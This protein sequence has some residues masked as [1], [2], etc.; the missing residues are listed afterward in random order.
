MTSAFP[1]LS[2]NNS[3]S[4]IL[5]GQLFWA[6]NNTPRDGLLFS[7]ETYSW[8]ENPK[9]KQLFDNQGHQFIIDNLDN[10]FTIATIEQ[11]IK[12][13]TNTS[14]IGDRPLTGENLTA[15][16]FNPGDN[17]LAI[18][19]IY[20]DQ[21]AVAVDTTL[22]S[23]G[24]LLLPDPD[25]WTS[26]EDAAG[27]VSDES[28]LNAG[29]NQ[30]DVAPSQNVVRNHVS[31][32][33]FPYT[34]ASVIDLETG[35]APSI[36]LSEFVVKDDF[37]IV[38]RNLFP[39]TTITLT[40]PPGARNTYAWDIDGF[41]FTTG[42]V[43]PN[44]QVDVPAGQ[45]AQVFV[46]TTEETI[47]VRPFEFGVTNPDVTQAD[48]QQE[49]TDRQN[50]DGAII[51]DLNTRA[52][53]SDLQQEITDR[54]NADAAI[55]TAIPNNWEDLD[56]VDFTNAPVTGGLFRFNGTNIE[57]TST[58]LVDVDGCSLE[59]KDET[60]KD[61]CNWQYGT[62]GSA[63]L[64]LKRSLGSIATPLAVTTGTK[65][66]GFAFVGDDL[67]TTNPGYVSSE[68]SSTALEPFTA[69]EAGSRMDF[70]VTPLGTKT[71]V[72][73][74]ST[75]NNGEPVLPQYPD[76]RDDG[77]TG[78]VLYTTA[79]GQLQLGSPQAIPPGYSEYFAGHENGNSSFTIYD[80]DYVTIIW[81]GTA[82]QPQYLQKSTAPIAW[83]RPCFTAFKIDGNTGT[84]NG[85]SAWRR[86]SGR[87]T[88]V[89]DSFHF[90]SRTKNQVGSFNVE[91]FGSYFQVNLTT[92]S[93]VSNFPSY[94]L[95]LFTGDN[96][97]VYYRFNKI[98]G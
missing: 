74:L 33:L 67:I 25:E 29:T 77:P 97:N 57:P 76:T 89:L 20:G 38:V 53:D 82:K 9:L 35:D 58:V 81:N 95:Y 15:P 59:T 62:T 44:S 3:V 75:A 21:A 8:L 79:T 98:G 86:T 22:A 84:T 93:F 37:P 61:W 71:P 88:L 64:V 2:A 1:R 92:E 48:L 24:D 12:G 56:N 49:I 23:K 26:T 32:E 83:G 16:G 47:F 17:V 18:F 78:K 96:D 66:G 54:Q 94:E 36:T 46:S 6:T 68:V 27:L 34:L 70:E 91:D 14:Q 7:G 55:I 69:T 42:T 43:I 52:L 39:S 11:N 51:S 19:G 13:T 50:A 30:T 65:I 5:V 40:R 45:F 85:N 31:T 72:V 90:F 4:D 28:F 60:G 73:F 41:S 87:P 80:D 10:T 63:F